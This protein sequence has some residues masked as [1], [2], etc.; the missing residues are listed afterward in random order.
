MQ[1]SAH[2]REASRAE[3]LTDLANLTDCARL[4]DMDV[5]GLEEAR[6]T[7]GEIVDRARLADQP[8]LI[9]RQ[10]KPAAV[11]IGA[12]S[13]EAMLSLLADAA[14]GQAERTQRLTGKQV[15]H[16]DGDPRNNDL[17][18]LRVVDLRDNG[19]QS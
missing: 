1:A 17:G 19:G 9:T 3:A 6:R 11:V 13:Y 7:L 16:K 15:V 5:T 2:H 12:E 4:T 18:N 14:A 8:T 10:G